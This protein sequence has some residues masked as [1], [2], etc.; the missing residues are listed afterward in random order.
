MSDYHCSKQFIYFDLSCVSVFFG[1]DESASG[2]V[3]DE[4]VFF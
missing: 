3:K 4:S 1:A 2:R